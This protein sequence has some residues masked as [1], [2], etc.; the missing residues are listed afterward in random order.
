MA[1]SISNASSKSLIPLL[2]NHNYSIWNYKLEA[3]FLKSNLFLVVDG[4]E[5]DLGATNPTLQTTWKNKDAQAWCKLIL[6]IGDK[7]IQC[8]KALK[9]SRENWGKLKAIYQ[10][11]NVATQVI[12][13]TK[14]IEIHMVENENVNE[15][16]DEFL[17]VLLMML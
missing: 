13:Y 5:I 8:V 16:L 3:L 15:F 9:T 6:N 11:T 17:D 2:T 14:L 1:I 10:Q 4:T 7:S 12:S